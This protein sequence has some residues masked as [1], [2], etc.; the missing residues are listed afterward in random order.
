MGKSQD[1]RKRQQEMRRAAAAAAITARGSGQPAP[2]P[3]RE[4][5][6]KTVDLNASPQENVD[7]EKAAQNNHYDNPAL[8]KTA[9]RELEASPQEHPGI[10]FG[11]EVLDGDSY[12]MEQDPTTKQQ[13]M[14]P[15]TPGS[16]NSTKQ[17]AADSTDRKRKVDSNKDNMDDEEGETTK[18]NTN[19]KKSK[20]KSKSAQ[21]GPPSKESNKDGSS[22]KLVKETAE[23]AGE[24][25]PPT[26]KKNKKKK[27]KKPKP[28]DKKESDD[29][30]TSNTADTSTNDD[31]GEQQIESMQTAWS[32]QTGG[33]M[34][35]PALCASLVRQD[36]WSPTP[37]QAAALPAAVLGRRNIVGA[38]PTGSGKTLAFLMPIGQFLLEHEDELQK[39]RQQGEALSPP[40]RRLQA[41]ILT[42][43]RELALQI[44]A[45]SD[46]LLGKRMV[47]SL[48]GGMAHVKQ[49]RVL[50]KNRPP[51]LVATP[52]RC[53][54]MMSSRE[55]EHLNELSQIRFLVI[56]EADRMIQQGSF[57]QLGRI[58]D[59]VQ[60]ANPMD[61]DDSD[62]EDEFDEDEEDDDDRLLGLPGVP[63]EAKLTMLNDNILAEIARQRGEDGEEEMLE[64][65][66]RE[67]DD[68]E[69]ATEG[70]DDEDGD[71]E[72]QISLPPPPPVYRQTF[73]Y[74]ATLTLPASVNFSK[75]NS[76][77]KKPRYQAD[78]D[79]AIAEILEKSRAK[80][81][82]KIVDLSNVNK[83]I[84]KQTSGQSE[85]KAEKE[86]KKQD[87]IRLP[88][89]LT[90]QQ[91]KCT[92]RHKDS[93]LYA[94]LMT[95][96]EG[97]SGP[98]LV[99][100]NSIAGVRRVGTTLQALGMDV[101]ILHAQM[102]Q[103]ARL[104]AVELLQ[105]SKKRTV[106]IATDVAARG[107]D[108]PSVASVVHYDTARTVDS[109][110]H[111]S[112]RTARGVG[113]KAVGCSVSLV[114]SNEDKMHSSITGALQV[115]FEPVALDGRLLQESQERVNLATK[116]AEVAN[117]E[118]KNQRQN[119]WLKEKAEG[120][121]F[122]MDEDL[123]E[124]GL[125]QGD[126]REQAKFAEAQKARKRLA[127][128]LAQPMRT[129]RFGKFL[130]TNSA[131]KND[132]SLQAL[133]SN[134]QVAVRTKK[135]RRRR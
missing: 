101:R 129:Q 18:G 123:L 77:K 15:I 52:G 35:H 111:R 28:A 24:K 112:G 78:V 19:D 107:L 95:T 56:D 54:E 26:K 81:K 37:I 122:D 62:D 25:D 29:A 55:Y 42:P 94:Y 126:Q 93:H 47:G 33:L 27:K 49:I 65:A 66:V 6:W 114:A 38:A 85:Q 74:S 9:A 45:E 97:S 51:I 125:A 120:A 104:K 20:K 102:Q 14:V 30:G 132:V 131:F 87:A 72:S 5:G 71:E 113:A 48:V 31:V 84:S 57:P 110:V 64:P 115:Q 21:T 22:V 67:M 96:A 41:L 13:V 100:C 92:Q 121:G 105:E 135:R 98:C 119:Q 82:T 44:Q 39:M 4:F 117:L 128:L 12:R 50:G 80:G 134:T 89:G 7:D 86:S 75:R 90:L 61:D 108:I 40:D 88:A 8:Q 60:Q 116:V 3:K 53:W 70:V 1:R 17:P 91:I 103:R 16:K 124:D 109:F 118:R 68:D 130:S 73:V 99:F 43:T 83:K 59:A 23:E 69:F 10:F 32:A 58:L 63:G 127:E 34:L 76:D 2:P 46:K 106:V 36:F 79:G 11:L 133:S